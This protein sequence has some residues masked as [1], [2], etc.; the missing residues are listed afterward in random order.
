VERG[1]PAAT[2]PSGNSSFLLDMHPPGTL[3][4][5]AAPTYAQM[6]AWFFAALASTW[7]TVPGITFT[8]VGECSSGASRHLMVTLGNQ[9]NGGACGPDWTTCPLNSSAAANPQASF[10]ETVV[11]EIGHGLG[12]AHE[13]Q[14]PGAPPLCAREQVI[15]DACSRCL[16]GTQCAVGDF[17]M[18][19]LVPATTTPA[20]LAPT[21]RMTAQ[22]KNQ[23]TPAGLHD[24]RA[25]AL[26][27]GLGHELL[28]P[29]QRSGG[30][31][32]P[33]H[34]E[35]PPGHGDALPEQSRLPC[36][37]SCAP[38]ATHLLG[39]LQG[40][41]AYWATQLATIASQICL[42]EAIEP[43]LVGW[44]PSEVYSS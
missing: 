14:V 11:H 27:P 29:R 26:R 15:R 33:G 4:S 21:Q 36:T 2:P 44:M 40:S 20:T 8:D 12:L 41:A 1:E 30:H 22:G 16:A 10:S 32:L 38:E 25:H 31:R 9:G 7:A 6:R 17:T 13:H 18:C 43:A 24:T 5:P 3:A 28:Q 34:E 23:R 19:G 42:E 35:R 39:P 37:S